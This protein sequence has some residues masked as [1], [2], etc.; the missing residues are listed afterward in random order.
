MTHDQI[1]FQ[2]EQLKLQIR[3]VPATDR[4]SYEATNEKVRLNW[5]TSYEGELLE[6]PKVVIFEFDNRARSLREIGYLRA[7]AGVD[8]NKLAT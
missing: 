1:M 6:L 8:C 2:C 5:S 4:R 7:L 3:Q